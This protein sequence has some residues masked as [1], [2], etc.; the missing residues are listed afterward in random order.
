MRPNVR[1]LVLGLGAIDLALVGCGGLDS[2]ADGPV[3][4]DA[5]VAPDAAVCNQLTAAAWAQ[6]DSYLQSTS[7]QAC[8]VDSD[9]SLLWLQPSSCVGM[10]GLL[11]GTADVSAVTAAAIGACDQYFAAGCVPSVLLCPY[12]PAVCDHGTCAHGS[13]TGPL[14]AAA[15]AAIDAGAPDGSPPIDASV[16]PDAPFDIDLPVTLDATAAPDAAVCDQLAAVAQ[17]QVESYLQSTYS[18]ACQVDSDCSFLQPR[19]LSCFAACG[20]VVMRTAD[21]S[22][23]TAAAAGVCDQYFGAGCPEK[24]LPCPYSRAVCDHGTC[25]KGTVP[26]GPSG[27]TDA[28]IDAGTGEVPIDGGAG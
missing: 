26:G 1:R 27:S 19:S 4:S 20:N 10:C 17:A 22:A 21:I 18:L 5:R 8:Q 3:T 13:P 23:I 14:D 28:A 11:I 12:L 6:F 15:D 16:M 25:T 2:T 24:I 7:S 9:C